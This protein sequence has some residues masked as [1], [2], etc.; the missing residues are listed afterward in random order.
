NMVLKI[1]L[2]E[3]QHVSSASLLDDQIACYFED[4]GYAFIYL[5][6]LEKRK[7]T[8]VYALGN[9]KM[10]AHIFNDGTYNVYAFGVNDNSIKARIKVYGTQTIRIRCPRPL[11]VLSASD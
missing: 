3:G 7:Y 11:Q 4:E 1:R 9:G 10:P 6:P 8:F 5:P 2:D